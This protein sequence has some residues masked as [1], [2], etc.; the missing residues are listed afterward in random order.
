M[1]YS[2]ENLLSFNWFLLLFLGR[3]H[4]V[5]VDRSYQNQQK[6]KKKT[7]IHVTCKTG[8]NKQS[9]HPTPLVN[10]IIESG[11]DFGDFRGKASLGRKIPSFS[12]KNWETDF[13]TKVQWNGVFM[14]DG[15]TNR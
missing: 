12:V 6:A 2:L 1:N 14:D 8:N 5:S 11:W 10:P 15:A 4:Q 13:C 7:Q 9:L 3:S